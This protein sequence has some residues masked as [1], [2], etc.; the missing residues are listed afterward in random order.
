MITPSKLCYCPKDA[1]SGR[2][3][4]ANASLGFVLYQN[5]HFFRTPSFRR[6][7]ATIR[8]LSGSIESQQRIVVPQHV[9]ILF[10]PMVRKRFNHF[11]RLK[12]PFLSPE[13]EDTVF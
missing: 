10:R 12:L 7:R 6:Q 3:T 8:V 13:T 1:V 4:L 5:D 9:E 2:K 11:L